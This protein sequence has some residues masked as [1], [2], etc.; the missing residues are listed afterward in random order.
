MAKVKRISLY[1]MIWCKIRFWQSLWD[2]SDRD[3]ASLLDISERTLKDYDRN[4]KN[5]TL[6]KI[7]RFLYVN[8]MELQELIGL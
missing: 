1:K 2:V 3:L 7:D 6:E 4:A 5:V 8:H